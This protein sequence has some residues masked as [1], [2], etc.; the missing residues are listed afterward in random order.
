MTGSYR[1]GSGNDTLTPSSGIDTVVFEST[2]SANGVDEIENF[3]IGSGGDVLKVS[4]FLDVPGL[5]NLASVVNLDTGS[6]ATTWANGDVLIMV[7]SGLSTPT[8]IEAAFTGQFTTNV[9][10]KAVIITA[11]VVGDASVWY[12]VNQDDITNVSATEITKVA[13]L[14]NL[15]NLG[16]SGYAFT[17]AN[18]V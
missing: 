17:S 8:A 16:I 7:G 18:F 3:K 9:R 10:G 12:L 15:A 13:T 5:S 6:G 1:L 14:E 4:E 11:D 2:G